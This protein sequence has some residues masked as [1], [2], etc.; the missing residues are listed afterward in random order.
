MLAPIQI[1]DCKRDSLI[2]IESE[3]IATDHGI[4]GCKFLNTVGNQ[5]PDIYEQ[6]KKYNSTKFISFYHLGFGYP[7]HLPKKLKIVINQINFILVTSLH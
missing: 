4:S 1:S 3:N 2:T 6:Q 7:A 5:D